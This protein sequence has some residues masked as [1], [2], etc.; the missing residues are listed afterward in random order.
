MYKLIKNPITNEI[1]IVQHLA[2]NAYIPFD[3]ANTDYN[4]F[5]IDLTNGAELQDANTN[6]MTANQI[7][8]LLT[9]LP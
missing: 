8:E 4:Q 5:K 9:T 7:S 2:D 1:N 3:P 6:V